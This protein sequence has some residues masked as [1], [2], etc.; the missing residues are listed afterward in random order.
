VEGQ[1][2][3][4]GPS[5]AKMKEALLEAC[6]YYH[7]NLLHTEEGRTVLNYLFDRGI[8]LDFITHFMVGLSPSQNGYFTKY[9]QEKGF[10]K[11]ILEAAGLITLKNNYCRDFFLDRIMFPIPDATG[12][13][14]GFSARKYKEETYGGKYINTAETA[15]FKKSR[16][17]FGLNHSRRSIAKLRKALIVEGQI[18]ALRLIQEGFNL[19]VAGQGTAFGEGHV[20]ELLNLGVNLVYLALDSDT[21]GEEATQKIG[22]FF[23]REGVEVKVVQL[24]DGM[25]PDSY[26][27]QYDAGRFLNLMENGIDYISFLVQHHS[28]K[29]NINSPAGKN[30]LVQLIAKQV[31]DW[32]HPVMVEES[33]RKLAFLTHVKEEMVGA[34][35]DHVPNVYLK[36]ASHS[37]IETIDA[38]L[39]LETDFLRWLHLMGESDVEFAALAKA[40]IATHDLSVP[41]C[42]KIY[43][44]LI[45]NFEEKKPV[46]F[47][48]LMIQMD[49]PK[50]QEILSGLMTKK[51]NQAR[52][53][54]HFTETIQAILDRNWMQKREEI[55]MKIQSGQS[56]DEEAIFLAEQFNNLKR[57]TL[58]NH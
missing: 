24:P 28:K 29:I 11:D 6:R 37:A 23:Q 22:N 15:L 46:D 54:P 55:K 12:A 58:Q 9:M 16:V 21:A 39:I 38:D 53:L 1:D 20:Q 30:E 34:M 26:L 25:D 10:Y 7:F 14:I 27:R 32:K 49:D 33:L 44:A 47:V 50:T 4:K 35:Q 5:K 13:V 36:S 42:Q 43:T 51:V 19:T 8:D 17:L 56:S 57:P 31:R 41:A 18:D 48:S 3:P 45:S 52:A 40:N 2:E